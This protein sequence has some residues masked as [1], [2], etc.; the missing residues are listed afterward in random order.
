MGVKSWLGRLR[1]GSDTPMTVEAVIK[2]CKS[3]GP[4]SHFEGRNLSS[5]DLRGLQFEDKDLRSANLAGTQVNDASFNNCQLL[6]ACLQGIDLSGA[7]LSGCDL[8]GTDLRDAKLV[9]LE[10]DSCYFHQA[11]FTS[12]DLCQAR[13][14]RCRFNGANLSG[15]QLAGAQFKACEFYGARSDG[16]DLDT[17]SFVETI[18]DREALTLELAFSSADSQQRLADVEAQFSRLM[19]V[20]P[21]SFDNREDL[22]H[23]SYAGTHGGR[24]YRLLV[25]MALGFVDLQLRCPNRLGV[26]SLLHHSFLS[27]TTPPDPD[28]AAWS[29]VDNRFRVTPV[30]ENVFLTGPG[31][32]VTAQQELLARLPQDYSAWI[33]Q[34]MVSAGARE[35][36]LESDRISLRFPTDVRY[37]DLAN[38]IPPSLEF[39]GY[40]AEQLEGFPATQQ[41]ADIPQWV[42]CDYC[43][44]RVSVNKEW[45]C[46]NCGAPL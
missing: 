36:S 23:W 4:Y 45:K 37:L 9:G 38:T 46:T 13:F 2:R 20:L 42:V 6:S 27:P 11:D 33:G 21:G 7:K 44:N 3:S 30:A 22:G 17:A 18:P 25:T 41:D 40:L 19:A 5:L 1:G 34:S 39:I 29:P 16:A 14:S 8:D 12:A 15:V 35:L 32:Q 28:Q 31:N 24:A 26:L 10:A 43:Q